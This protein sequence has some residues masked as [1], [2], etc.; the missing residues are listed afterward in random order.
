[1]T[2][3][4]SNILKRRYKALILDVDGT[5]IPNLIHGL[6]SETV[7]KA[8]AKARKKL[9][10]GIATSRPLFML[11]SLFHMLQLSGP[12]IINGGAQIYD[13]SKK[14]FLVEHRI[15]Q[16]TLKQI[17]T[18]LQKN[19]VYFYMQDGEKNIASPDIQTIPSSTIQLYIPALL[20]QQ[21]EQISTLISKFEDISLHKIVSWETSWQMRKMR[22]VPE[23]F[24]QYALQKPTKIKKTK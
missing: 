1:M 2:L 10:V 16:K 9:H 11:D 5:L 19:H 23:V 17:I 8:L 24:L 13:V 22:V 18:A 14:V 7:C 15:Q 4:S 20:L 12:S 21:T 3:S 6:P